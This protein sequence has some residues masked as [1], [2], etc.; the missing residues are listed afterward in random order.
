MLFLITGAIGSGKTLFS[1]EKIVEEAQK[2]HPRPIF[3]NIT[4][5][6]HKELGTFSLDDPLLWNSCPENSL[7]FIDECHQHFPNRPSGSKVPQYVDDF[8]TSRHK[9]YDIYLITQ[10][11]R[12]L[13]VR[14]R[15]LCQTH[16]H[17]RRIGGLKGNRITEYDGVQLDVNE[18]IQTKTHTKKFNKKLFKY[19]KS[20]SFHTHKLNIPRPVY[21]FIGCL[22]IVICSFLFI[23]N[24]L[25]SMSSKK[26]EHTISNSSTT[27]IKN[28]DLL[29]H[30]S[31]SIY[32]NIIEMHYI[33][34][35]KSTTYLIVNFKIQIDEE[36]EIQKLLSDF[37]SYRYDDFSNSFIF[38]ENMPDGTQIYY[39][40]R[41]HNLNNILPKFIPEAGEVAALPG[42]STTQVQ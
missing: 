8:A 12:K 20:A 14:I 35:L 15:E 41:S 1:V 31:K 34:H 24:P 5:F 23:G 19:Y 9:A 37:S 3:T 38:T 11:P 39:F 10:H 32:R 29:N 22:L 40:C 33:G 25:K 21:Y 28:T 17:I 7:I 27:N 4:N 6:A 42:N 36:T 13:D 16:F 2:E 26:T 30:N 18:P